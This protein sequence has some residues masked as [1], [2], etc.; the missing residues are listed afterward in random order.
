MIQTPKVEK[1]VG[2]RNHRFVVTFCFINFIIDTKNI[3]SK[4]FKKRIEECI[5][6]YNINNL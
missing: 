3:Y 1:E 5:R 6:K 2:W 4:S